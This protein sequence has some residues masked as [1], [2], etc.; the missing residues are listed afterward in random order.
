MGGWEAFI[1]KVK[2]C[3]FWTLECLITFRQ[4]VSSFCL[5]HCLINAFKICAAGN[6]TAT[7]SQSKA[8]S[9][10]IVYVPKGDLIVFGLNT[11]LL[12]SSG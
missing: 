4:T 7:H 3:V 6:I 11:R 5:R 8:K 12:L 2:L 1:G 9:S 10:S